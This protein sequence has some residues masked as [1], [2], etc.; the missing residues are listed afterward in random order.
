FQDDYHVTSKLVLNLGLRWET[1]LPPVEEKDRWSDF[2][3]TTPNPAAGNLLGALIYAGTGTGRQG[4]RALADS[5]FAGF[6]PHIGFAYSLN[7]KTVVRAN[8]ARSFGPIQ[9][10]SGSTHQRGFTQ[11]FSFSNSNGGLT[12]T[13]LLNQ[14]LPP[15]PQPPFI[16]P[17]FANKDNIPW[18]QGQEATRAPEDNNF[19]ISIQRQLTGSLALEVA[20]NAVMGSH[21][22]SDLLNYDQLNPIYLAKYGYNLLNQ[23][24]NSP[25]AVA[26]G[27]VAPYPNFAKD[28]GSGATVARALRPYPQYQSIDT[29]NGEGDH[30][31]HS[32]YHAGMIRLEKRY[33][34][35]LVFETSYVFSK[36]LTDA[37]SYWGNGA[38]NGN[39]QGAMDQYNR[40]LEKSIGQFDVTHNFKWG[41]S[42]ELPF[43]KGKQWMNSGPLAYVLGNWRVSGIAVYQSGIP[44]PLGTSFG[45]PLFNSRLAPYVT[46]YDGWRAP[47]SGKFDPSVDNFFVPYG[48][49]P[50]PLQGKDASGNLIP[51][52]SSFGN[53]TRFNPKVRL[54]WNLNENVALA[55]EIP[56]R[57]HLR[58]EI[59]AEAFNLFNRVRFGS[60]SQQLQDPN[61]GHLTSNDEI[62]TPRE[63]QLAAKLYF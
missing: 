32:T 63:L 3:P 19:N 45:L 26:A 47:Y 42:Y 62:N 10:V 46:S 1:T 14:G 8:Y 61:F 24:Y 39:T 57:E 16:S 28:W 27:I 11:T 34:S 56:I 38:F 59:R 35:G 5:W 37:D 53:A 52:Y 30:S 48:T 7:D 20:Y 18:W 31:G 49:G 41:G 44:I 55:K 2:S 4:S 29:F 15:W 51:G 6:G 36:L 17:S 50:F 9:T 43:G 58:F 23:K 33:S 22:Q 12:P 60:G 21:L 25:A 40:R 54:P 13:F